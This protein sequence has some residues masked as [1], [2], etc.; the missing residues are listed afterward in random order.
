MFIPIDF[1]VVVANTD[2][3]E[4]R[5]PAGYA[6][7]SFF[8]IIEPMKENKSDLLEKITFAVV[9]LSPILYLGNFFYLSF[10][11]SKI[12]FIYGLVQIVLV[13]WL[14]KIL[15]DRTYRLEKKDWFFISPIILY[16]ICLTIA[17]IFGENLQMSFWSS[18]S[19][20][21]GLLSIY[22]F[23][24]FGLVVFSLIKR[25]GFNYL[26]ILLL[27]FVF[28]S[29]ILLISVWLGNEGLD[30]P[31]K[32]LEKSK[33]GG[34]IG[35]SSL[36]ASVLLF[37]F[38]FSLFLLA[39]KNISKKIKTFL[40]ANISLIFFSPLFL[41]VLSGFSHISARAVFYGIIAG[42][43]SFILFYFVFSGNKIK[44]I[45]SLV[46]LGGFILVGSILFFKVFDYKSV[47]SQKFREN[48][49]ENRLIFWSITKDVIKERPLFGYG[50]E[51][52]YLAQQKYFDSRLYD[53]SSSVEVWND[54]AH[55][56]IFGTLIDIGIL[57][58]LSYL[59]L[60]GSLFYFIYKAFALSRISRIQASVLCSLIVSYF[61]QNLFAFDSFVSLLLL[62]VYAFVI[63][64]FNSNFVEEKIN[65]SK[66]NN[67]LVKIL[68][69]FLFV[70]SFTYFV[71]KPYI[72]IYKLSHVMSLSVNK[73][74]DSFSA[75]LK[76]SSVGNSY[77]VAEIADN[78]YFI[79]EKNRQILKD[80]PRIS[81]V[82]KDILGFLK[83][84]EVIS[85][86]ENSNYR[87]FL[88]MS[89]ISNVYFSLTYN[90]DSLV[91]EKAISFG[92]KAIELSPNDLQGY[93]A[94]AVTYYR[95]KDKADAIAILNKA[96]EIAPEVA[97]T[98]ELLGSFL[99]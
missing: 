65:Y 47:V 13:V 10:A 51:N 74:A 95:G 54:R 42:A 88:N 19:R 91:Y 84:L 98:K 41:S 64:S 38:F 86:K 8:C 62:F 82:Q 29:F 48:I 32:I 24:I 31:F 89:R 3:S 96:L 72:K 23:F 2:G 77:D 94:L 49:G 60:L 1:S 40:I 45:V 35:N 87:L 67:Y 52:Y 90:V 34:L 28:G 21:T 5:R 61:I 79:Y 25:N 43:I 11:T 50:P 80:D 4:L 6:G 69:L 16:V 58:L 30:L 78:Y 44:R 53:T 68:I 92:K 99:K 93:W 20:G 59:F 73:R 17:G 14:L 39:F 66:E 33:G 56:I 55:N 37:S 76:G 27:S 46:L 18:L 9:F 12:F 97:F 36:A 15:K 85:E 26:R 7:G 83:Y 75:L 71:V 22:H 81:Y 63:Y 70:F 57:G